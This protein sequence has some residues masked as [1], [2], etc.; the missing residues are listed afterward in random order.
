MGL[1]CRDSNDVR[2]TVGGGVPLLLS[3]QVSRLDGERV[4]HDHFAG[5]NIGKRIANQSVDRFHVVVHERTNVSW[6]ARQQSKPSGTAY[7]CAED[8]EHVFE[9][10]LACD[11]RL[12]SARRVHVLPSMS[13]TV[14]LRNSSCR[15]SSPTQGWRHVYIS[16]NQRYLR[17]RHDRA[18]IPRQPRQRLTSQN[19]APLPRRVSGGCAGRAEAARAAFAQDGHITPE[20]S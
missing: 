16:A 11:Q 19:A 3:H 18:G 1:I 4:Q 14:A 7:D 8:R 12:V 10:G 20:A 9:L 5:L 17:M 13:A 2:L 15:T 6:L